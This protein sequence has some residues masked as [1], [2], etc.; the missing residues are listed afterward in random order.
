MGK[1]KGRHQSL[2]SFRRC[3]GAAKGVPMATDP[4]VQPAY[5]AK[6]DM[7]TS[8]SYADY[9][10]LDDVL[11]AQHPL[12]PDHNELLFIVIHHVTELWLKLAL[13]ELMAARERIRQDDLQPAFKMTARVS[14][15]LEQMIAGWTVLAT[16][17][18]SEYSIIRPHLGH[19]S[20]FQSYQY[21][22]LEFVL[23]NKNEVM[24][25]PHQHRRDR[26]SLLEAQLR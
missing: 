18:P 23:G 9:L 26:L 8:M 24:I 21:R 5:G 10:H 14:R 13:H 11:S 4:L 16:L 17:T 1:A 3:P 15:T 2:Q 12:S 20:G 19:A 7:S 22:L 6:L 25:Q